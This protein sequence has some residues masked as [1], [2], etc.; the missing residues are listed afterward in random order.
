M[1]VPETFFSV[2]EE[3]W[4]FLL[5]CIFGAV[6]G[7]YYD[8]FR[9]LR[10]AVPHHSFF[11]V[12]EDVVFLGTYAV[13]LSAF[14]SAAAR[15]ELRAYFALGGILGFTLYYFT[16]GK[17]VIRLMQKITGIIKWIF[18]VAVKPFKAIGGKF[19]GIAQ[20]IVKKNKNNSDHLKNNRRL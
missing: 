7:V 18:A 6:F 14:A 5:S 1:N 13:F 10:M 11:V 19:V 17:F 3:L 12:L 8:I 2:G 15:G 16:V 20:S 9:T 4:L